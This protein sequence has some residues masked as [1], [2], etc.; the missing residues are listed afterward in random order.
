MMTKISKTHHAQPVSCPLV[1]EVPF[2]D[3]AALLQHLR[4][5]QDL[6]FLDSVDRSPSL[7]RYSYL[8]Y[9]AF[10]TF[11]ATMG[12]AF[13]NGKAFEDPPFVALQNQLMLYSQPTLK[14]SLPPFQGGA[15]GY[16]SY[17]AGRLL[18]KLP[19][20]DFEHERIDD[21][22]L[23]FYD[24]ILAV[25]H[26]PD[27]GTN[28]S[29]ARAWIIS[30]GWPCTGEKQQTHARA[31]LDWFRS[32][33]AAAATKP[34]TPHNTPPIKGWRSNFSRSGYQQAIERTRHHI[35]EGDIFQANITQRFSASV[36]KYETATPLAYYL[37]LR[38]ENPAPF[39]AYLACG[40]HVIASSSPERFLTLDATGRAE[41][42][43]IKGT[44]PRDLTNPV[45]DQV[46]SK[47][48]LNSD[49]DR[50][51]NVMITDLMRNDLSRVCK[52]DSVKVPDLCRLESY[53]RVHHLVSVVIGHLK[54]GMGPVALLG[55]CFPG[56]S[57]TGAPKIRS[58]E[59][60]T[61][62]ENLP[63]GVYCG[64]IGYI[65]FDGTMDTNIAIRT[66]TFKDDL[67]HFGVGGG[68]TVLSD[69][70]AEYEE[71]LHK[72]AA[73]F[74]SLGTSVE[75]ERAGLERDK[76]EKDEES[77]DR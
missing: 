58:M 71:T 25:D 42:R 20:T 40:D 61:T 8:A 17:E 12:R 55:A 18:E 1:E 36:P 38:K 4:N 64:S 54:Q 41:T 6:A 29:P 74:K 11:R 35:L 30:T 48:L 45:R 9:S 14:E 57:I 68:I 2:T 66:V 21:I 15:I 31:R 51:E 16:I 46:L 33:L 27:G 62:L 53:A 34:P 67:V 75:E 13:W 5:H 23:P 56:G 76:T 52:P 72:A 26:F 43:P 60:I 63:R 19:S 32:E 77:P 7:G 39:A 70:A 47:N 50:A 65:G 22:H 24:V 73:I 3:P 59:I 49:K 10:G 28:A 44:A 69:P 37:Q